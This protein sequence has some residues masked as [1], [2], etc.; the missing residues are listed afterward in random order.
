MNSVFIDPSN[1]KTGF[2]FQEYSE[3][4]SQKN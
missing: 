2:N 3:I 4:F 1:R